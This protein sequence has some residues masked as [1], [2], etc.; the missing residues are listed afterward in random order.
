[1]TTSSNDR[2]TALRRAFDAAF[3]EPLVEPL[4]PPTAVVRVALGELEIGVRLV[5]IASIVR[6][7]TLLPV[8][9]RRRDLLGVAALRGA[10]V[11]VFSLESLLDLARHDAATTFLLVARSRP[12]VAFGCTNVVGILDVPLAALVESGAVHAPQLCVSP[13]G[14][15]LPIVSVASLLGAIH[16]DLASSFSLESRA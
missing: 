6:V 11:P 1:M 12:T 5:D 9:S 13:D 2:A 4:A 14:A 16:S 10:M 8:P 7:E 3:A 15:T